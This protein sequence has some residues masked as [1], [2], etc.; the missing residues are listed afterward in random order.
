MLSAPIQ[1][2]AQKAAAPAAQKAAA[3][4]AVDSPV[5]QKLRKAA[6]KQWIASYQQR[7]EVFAPAQEATPLLAVSEEDIVQRKGEAQA[8]IQSFRDATVAAAEAAAAA[9]AEVEQAAAAKGEAEQWIANWRA[10]VPEAPAAVISTDASDKGAAQQWIANW[11]AR[12]L[13]TF[14]C[15]KS[16][17][18][19][20]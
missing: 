14:C 1:A 12:V 5:A 6:V 7:S 13:S 3:P 8:W 16:V 20:V 15:T 17:Q 10:T 11:R 18:G 2:A 9:A 19:S 4:A